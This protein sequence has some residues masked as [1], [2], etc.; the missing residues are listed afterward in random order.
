MDFTTFVFHGGQDAVEM[1]HRLCGQRV[2]GNWA[3]LPL[4][5]AIESATEHVERCPALH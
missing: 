4:Y 2:E 5:T 1:Y 3:R